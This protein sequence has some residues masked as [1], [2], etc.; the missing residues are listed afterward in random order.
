MNFEDVRPYTDNDEVRFIDRNV[1]ARTGE[2]HIKSFTEERELTVVLLVDVSASGAFGSVEAS[3]REL[4]AEVAAMLAFSAI[5]NQDKVGLILFSDDIELFLPPRKGRAPRAA[6]HPRGALLPAARTRARHRGG[7]GL[8][9]QGHHPPR[10]GLPDLRLPVA[11]FLPAAGR[12][13]PPARSGSRA[14]GRSAGGGPAQRR[15]LSLEDAET[16]ALNE[17]NTSDRRVRAAFVN[18]VEHAPRAARRPPA[19]QP[20]GQH[21]LRTDPDY[22]PALRAF[23]RQRERRIARR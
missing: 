6:D 10:G 11:G 7:P 19:A 13:Q 15:P 1:T 16:G 8:S 20:G 18:A 4:A 2:L 14:G 22:L 17:V 9:Q 5:R 12:H 23:F 3:K 21:H